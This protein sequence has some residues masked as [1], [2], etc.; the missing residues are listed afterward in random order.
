MKR[1]SRTVDHSHQVDSPTA[2]LNA[3]RSTSLEALDLVTL[4]VDSVHVAEPRVV[5]GLGIDA[6]AR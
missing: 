3:W 1:E 5:V 2:Q 6:T 4:I